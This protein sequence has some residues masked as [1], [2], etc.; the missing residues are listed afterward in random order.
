MRGLRATGHDAGGFAQ[1]AGHFR[2]PECQA[3]GLELAVQYGRFPA[4][5]A[6]E[7]VRFMACQTVGG[8]FC[9]QL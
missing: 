1:L 9:L 7:K 2:G 4:H 5:S 3:K 6:R 8:T